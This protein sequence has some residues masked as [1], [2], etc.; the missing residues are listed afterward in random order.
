MTKAA[1]PAAVIKA[2]GRWSYTVESPQGGGGTLII[3][4]D[5]ENY[6]GTII[7]S[8]NNRETPLKTV[9]VTGNELNCTYEVNFGGNTATLSIKAIVEG[10]TMTGNMTMGQFGSFPLK[11]TRAQ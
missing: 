11:G 3:T 6:S 9:T 10:D 1:D 2:E 8:R 4:K 5:G 7:S